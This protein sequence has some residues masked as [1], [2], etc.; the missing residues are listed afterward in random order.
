VIDHL[1]LHKT[2]FWAAAPVHHPLEM[3]PPRSRPDLEKI[4]VGHMLSA[5]R[6][7]CTRTQARKA[8]T[9]KLGF[10]SMRTTMAIFQ[11][12]ER[13]LRTGLVDDA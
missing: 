2:S 8:S 10:L 7:C 11:E 13:A 4:A 12:R 5:A 1:R 9:E 3:M 6:S